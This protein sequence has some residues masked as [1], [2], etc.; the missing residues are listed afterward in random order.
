MEFKARYEAAKAEKKVK[1]LTPQWYAFENPGDAVLGKLLGTS[2][3]Q[4]GLGT[5][6]YLQYLMLTDDGLVKFSLGAATDRELSAVLV[7]G[8]IYRVEYQG[9]TKIK[10]GRRVNK[11]GVEMLEAAD[12]EEPDLSETPF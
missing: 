11:F 9:Q 7:V 8:G 10:G 1:V 4:S 12:G 5:G 3:V 2:P 6:T